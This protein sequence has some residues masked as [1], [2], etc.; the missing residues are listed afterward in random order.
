[1]DEKSFSLEIITPMQSVFHQ[2]VSHVRIPGHDGYWGILAG[3]EPYIFAL[4]V[5]EIKVE[6][7]NKTLHF[8]TSGGIAEVLPD[9]MTILVESAEDA[10]QIDIKRAEEAKDRAAHRLKEKVADVDVERAKSAFRR[11]DNR[12]KI[13]HQTHPGDHKSK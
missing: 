3:H 8:A 12:L 5:G 11:A 10:T 2:Q 7:D 4:E 9:K 13:S 1:M 6:H